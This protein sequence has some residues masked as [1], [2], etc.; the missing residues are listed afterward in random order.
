MTAPPQLD[1]QFECVLVSVRD[2]GGKEGRDGASWPVW[3]T[4]TNG[5]IVGC[6]FVISATGVQPN[7]GV[8]GAEFEVNLLRFELQ[9]IGCPRDTRSTCAT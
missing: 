6:D 5:R 8:L 2:E 3:A 7:T 1:I 4:L 9:Q